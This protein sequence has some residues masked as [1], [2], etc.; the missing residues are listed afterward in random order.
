M[1][2]ILREKSAGRAAIV[3][4]TVD[5][6]KQLPIYYPD[7]PMANWRALA[8]GG[9]ISSTTL[10]GTISVCVVGRGAGALGA[11]TELDE[12]AKK[13]PGLTIR[14]KNI[15]YDTEVELADDPEVNY[16]SKWGRI[17]TVKPGQNHQE[18]GCMRFPSIALLTWNYISKA[19]P[20]QGSEPLVRFPNPGRV[21]TQF[22]YR[23]M[24]VVFE[25]D[26]NGTVVA[27]AGMNSVEQIA[28]LATME[29]V[30]NGVITYMLT[31][32]TES[33]SGRNIS[34]FAS[35]LVG[36]P[37][38][39]P[40]ILEM[41]EEQIRQTWSEWNAF[42]AE[43]DT[44]LIDIVQ[45]AID[46]LIS[47]GAI[48]V[49][50]S[51]DRAYFIELFGRY[52]LGTGGFRPL[53][54]VT[55][56][57]IARL[58][59]WNYSDEYLFPG[60]NGNSASAN[61]DFAER[62]FNGLSSIQLES[63]VQKALFIGRR[64]ED[65][66]L[67]VVSYNPSSTSIEE[68]NYDYVILAT[69]HHAAQ[70]ILEP[71]SGMKPLENMPRNS[72]LNFEIN[73]SHFSYNTKDVFQHPFDS[74]KGATGSLYAGLKN[75]HMMRT[76]KYF[77]DV[78]N[79][80][81]EQYAPSGFQGTNR[82]KMVISDT[83]LAATYCLEGQNGTTN[84]LVS[85][86]WGDEASN[87]TSALR[88]L[89]SYAGSAD[90]SRLRVKHAQSAN[91]FG[92]SKAFWVSDML[93]NAGSQSGYMYDWSAD[94]DS[95][96]GFK[97]DGVSETAFSTAL[98]DHYRTSTHITEASQRLFVAGDSYSHYGG[99]LEG[100]FMTGITAVAA[101]MRSEFGESAFSEEGLRLFSE[102]TV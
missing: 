24:N 83:D 6:F 60:N 37:G 95:R 76:T 43:R 92:Q 17:F 13:N 61:V 46:D 69:A 18:I 70:R 34:Y 99:W 47:T 97:L 50:D 3:S 29:A 16:D 79:A 73:G 31:Q 54:N 98:Y 30:K 78:S 1:F 48:E 21:P 5:N 44:P 101:V 38:K 68:V 9:M 7:Q 89:S 91:R 2:H 52:G 90:D 12:I 75:L 19:Y 41:T 59:I 80:E 39:D 72:T 32:V 15:Y 57:E 86:A 55:F 56:N 40:L 102:P 23:D 81:F 65:A 27:I 94:Q 87:E 26:G 28:N 82:V 8:L 42:L 71:F 49:T 100:A 51:R 64:F 25:V 11:M 63:S 53:N 36:D 45:K 62:L 33:S 58:L 85:Y 77:T 4:P 66:R 84:I 67:T 35:V 93:A 10:N 22:I 74:K 20:T 14:V 88:G 96:G